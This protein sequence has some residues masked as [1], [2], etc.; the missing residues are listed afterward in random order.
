MRGHTR[1][2]AP[3]WTMIC[4]AA[5]PHCLVTHRTERRS[6]LDLRHAR[7]SE[8]AAMHGRPMVN[9]AHSR[10]FN[11]LGPAREVARIHAYPRRLPSA[12]CASLVHSQAVRSHASLSSGLMAF[13]ACWRHSSACWRNLAASSSDMAKQIA[14][15]R[16]DCKK[17]KK[18]PL[19]II[20]MERG[21]HPPLPL[22]TGPFARPNPKRGQPLW[23]K[24]PVRRRLSPRDWRDQNMH[25]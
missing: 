15:K 12:D 21:Q 7:R 6:R 10:E 4:L 1:N 11:E 23:R 19:G 14:H 17:I 20:P 13:S 22:G 16:D 2:S 24:G 5:K 18:G 25:E 3:H 9:I 8:L